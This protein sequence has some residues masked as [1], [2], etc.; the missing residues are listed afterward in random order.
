[1]GSASYLLAL[2]EIAVVTSDLFCP[3]NN[4]NGYTAANFFSEP[5]CL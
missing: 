1:M 3:W 5:C 4:I 2:P